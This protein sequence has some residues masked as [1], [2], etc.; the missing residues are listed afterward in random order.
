MTEHSKSVPP[1]DHEAE[2]NQILRARREKLARLRELGVHPYPYRFDATHH[3]AD[4]LHD[5]DKVC[6]KEGDS[7]RAPKF[8]I[9]GRIVTVRDMGRAAFCHLRDSSG[10]MQLYFKKDIVGEQGYEVFKL[11]DIGDIIGVTGTAFRTKTGE[12]TLR[13][14]SFELLCKN[15]YPLPVVKEREGRVFDAFTDKEARYRERHVDLAVNPEEREVFRK[16]SA[17]IR[18]LRRFLDEHDFLEVETP[19]LQPLYGGAL[20]RPFSTDYYALERTFFLR[21]ADELYLKRLLVG[22]FEKVYEI[23]KAFRN[24][25]ID[26]LHN[27]E[28]TMLEFYQAYADYH[29]TMAFTEEMLR[30]CALQV[31]GSHVVSYRDAAIDFKPPF[32]RETF[33]GLLRNLTGKDLLGVSLAELRKVARDHGIE[34]T[35][36]MGEGKI[37]DELMKTHVH[38]SLEQPTIVYDYPLSLSPLAKKHRDNPKL[39]ERFQIFAAGLEL[40][41]AFSELNDPFDQRERFE[42]QQR[43]REAGEKET[44]PVD[45]DFLRALEY[46]MPPAS[47]VGIGIDRLTMLLTDQA[48]IREVILFPALRT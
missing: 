48:S 20:A 46:G 43:L 12:E 36:D 7:S 34:D 39:V 3:V 19:A 23:A 47:G 42:A 2:L 1:E 17:L 16:R 29:D 10:Q 5:F 22:G 25:G 45:E 8:S 11:L 24:E 38:A 40:C 33:Y 26:R 41:N 44:Q 9:A 6:E 31:T 32:R 18:T 30:E 21:I 35:A 14:A 27:P 28:F 15:I 37:L 4:I 13:V